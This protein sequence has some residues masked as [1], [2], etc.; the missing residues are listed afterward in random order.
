MPQDGAVLVEQDARL[1]ALAL[2]SRRGFRKDH[3]QTHYL[4]RAGDHEGEVVESFVT[5][6]RDKDAALKFIKKAIK[7][8]RSSEIMVTAG[9]KSYPAALRDIGSIEKQV[10]GPC[11]A[12][13]R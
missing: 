10:K 13:G 8:H 5:K 4:W 6:T 12:S 7:R 3:G 2:A 9:L 11:S 1:H